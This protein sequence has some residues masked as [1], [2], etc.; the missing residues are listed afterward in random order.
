MLVE[1]DGPEDVTIQA[2]PGK[3]LREMNAAC[4]CEDVTGRFCRILEASRAEKTTIAPE[5]GV[6]VAVPS[7]RQAIAAAK[8]ESSSLAF[9][10]HVKKSCMEH[11]FSGCAP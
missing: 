7:E 6:N 8:K 11:V 9:C 1:Y 2:D 4:T 10:V 5:T 3:K